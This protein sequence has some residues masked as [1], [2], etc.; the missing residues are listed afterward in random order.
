MSKTTPNPSFGAHS[1]SLS[2]VTTHPRYQLYSGSAPRSESVDRLEDSLKPFL[3]HRD[4]GPVEDAV[5]GV[6]YDLAP[7]FTNFSCRPVSD[8]CATASGKPQFT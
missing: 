4:L 3:R 6:A 7:P 8:H 5:E 2:V 1:E